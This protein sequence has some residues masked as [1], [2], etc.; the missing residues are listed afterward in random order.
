MS[1][2]AIGNDAKTVKGEGR[3]YLT[4]ILYLAPHTSAKV[5]TKA[6][7]LVNVCPFATKC[8]A[9]CL[10]SAGR[11]AMSNVHKG[12]V[13]K[14]RLLFKDRP[15]FVATLVKDTAALVRRARREDKTPT[16]RLNGTSDL[17]W[18]SYG[19][20]QAHSDVQFYDYTKSAPRMRRFL[21][22]KM[23]A[24][25]HLTFSRSGTNDSDCADVLQHGGNVAVVFDTPKGQPLPTRWHIPGVARFYP[26]IDGDQTDLRFLDPRGVIVGL[27]A[28]GKAKHD[29]S[30]F[31]VTAVNVKVGG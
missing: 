24:N 9:P 20:M 27:R 1:L 2:L 13:R 4:G 30:G 7:A 18:E 11:G 23:P 25:Y 5:R 6:G 14:T 8:K 29:A 21:A 22:G 12:R 19:V 26:V 15:A 10:V 17:G 28:K 3:G 31:T 16:A